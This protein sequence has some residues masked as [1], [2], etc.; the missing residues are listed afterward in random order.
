VLVSLCMWQVPSRALAQAIGMAR[1]G[2]E[3]S[4]SEVRLNHAYLFFCLTATRGETPF[5]YRPVKKQAR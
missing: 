4:D 3:R 1:A 5:L 2:L